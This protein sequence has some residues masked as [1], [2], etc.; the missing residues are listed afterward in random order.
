MRA[1]CGEVRDALASA[2]GNNMGPRHGKREDRDK[3]SE[4]KELREKAVEEFCLAGSVASRLYKSYYHLLLPSWS[5]PSEVAR[6]VGKLESYVEA[7]DLD[8]P[9]KEGLMLTRIVAYELE[10]EEQFSDHPDDYGY[11]ED[12]VEYDW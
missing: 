8:D 5:I 11:A 6:F 12:Y 4:K 10:S 1:R 2:Q 3:V 7:F 9:S